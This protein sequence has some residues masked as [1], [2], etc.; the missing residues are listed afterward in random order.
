MKTA[1]PQCGAEL[2]FRFDDSFVR[3]CGHCRAAVTRTDRGLETLGKIADLMPMQ[4]PLSL[5]A[6]GNYGGQSFLLTGKAQVRHAAGGVWQEWYAKFGGGT[7]GWLAEA[8]GRY[9]MTFEVP[10]L[11]VPPHYQLAPGAQLLLPTHAGQRTFTVAEVGVATY[12]AAD[13]EL[14]YRLTPNSM[15]RY[16]D[17]TD[18]QG[19]FATI[20]YGE[21]ASR[22]P[23]VPGATPP[24]VYVGGQIRLQD[25]HIIG[26]EA[27][28]PFS[29]AG[30]RITSQ[31]LACPSCNGSLELAAPDAALRV[32]CPYCNT[33]LD[34]QGGTLAVLAKLKQQARPAI[35]LGTRARLPEGEMTVIG[36]VQRSARVDGTWYPFDEYLL[37]APQLG[38]RWLVSSDGHWSYVQPVNPGACSSEGTSAVYQDVRFK[39]FQT[40]PLRV[41]RVLGEFYWRIEVGE[42]TTGEDFVSPPA[43]LSRESGHGEI[44][45]SLSTFMTHKELMAAVGEL[46]LPRGTGVA[47]NQPWPHT[48]IGKYCLLLVG[49]LLVIG[50]LLAA[51]TKARGVAAFSFDVPAG[52]GAPSPE[53]PLANPAGHVFFSEPFK[54]KGGENIELQLSSPLNNNWLYYVVDLV[55]EAQSGFITFDGNLEYYSG[56]DGGEYW[57]E[58]SPHKTQFL[59]PL[60]AGSYVARVEVMHGGS[61]GT[62]IDLPL[63]VTIRQNVFQVGW[64]GVALG[65]LLVLGGFFWLSSRRFEKK[66]WENS[67]YGDDDSGDDE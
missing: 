32:V 53:A 40:A 55:D 39:H 65:A 30:E 28:P 64:L 1:C 67:A 42:T 12:V 43:M 66:R 57:S 2:E 3:V 24:S 26:G 9:Y 58:G 20:D 31:R 51:T 16:V 47:P 17:L 11:P 14:P 23:R 38:F 8:Q 46:D 48:G 25:L 18:G 19:G 36:F 13:G 45:W 4:S 22:D 7:W 21:P 15:F 54:L 59:G 10:D 56:Y 44:N 27:P 50:I 63:N 5:F 49:A 35:K 34:V 37:H 60:P 29:P 33:M 52:A 41:D 6:D 62:P 61:L